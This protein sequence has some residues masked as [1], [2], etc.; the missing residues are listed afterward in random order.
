MFTLFPQEYLLIYKLHSLQN[1]NPPVSYRSTSS[2][3][4]QV[5]HSRQASNS[6]ISAFNFG[7]RS[8]EQKREVGTPT[9]AYSFLPAVNFDDFHTSLTSGEPLSNSLHGLG[10]SFASSRGVTSE[11]INKVLDN[12][13]PRRSTLAESDIRIA[14]SGSLMQRQHSISRVQVQS[15]SS[16]SKMETMGP[17]S[18]PL[19]A[20]G[21]RQSHFPTP[22]S[23]NTH[24]R[25]PRKSIG[26]GNVPNNAS[27]DYLKVRP[28]LKGE[29]DENGG[30]PLPFAERPIRAR[31][32]KNTTSVPGENQQSFLSVRNAKAKSLHAP[33]SLSHDYLSASS[34]APDNSWAMPFSTTRSPIRSND[35]GATTPSSSRRLSVMP[36]H[37]TGLGAR[38]IS[39]TDARRLKRMS[40]MP[41]PP[42]LPFTPPA[43]LPDPGYL[44]T[45]PAAESPSLIPRKS[46]TPSS[47]RTTPDPNR[48]SYCSTSSSTSYNSNRPLATT[49]RLPPSA[50]L[51]R[52]P[53]LKSR[54][55]TTTNGSEEEVPPVPAIPK[56]YESPKTELDLP[57]FAR[58]KSSL[59]DATSLNSNSTVDQLS[60]NSSDKDPQREIREHRGLALDDGVRADEQTSR[61]THNSIRNLQ[62]LRLPPLNLL[63]LNTPT[64][65]K[66]AALHDR[67]MDI[68][69]TNVTPPPRRSQLKTPS[70]PMTASKA[71]FFSRHDYKDESAPMPAHTR[72][73]SSHYA[74]RSESSSYRAASSS[75]SSVAGVTDTQT[76]L[77]PV[78]PFISSS[79]PKNSLESNSVRPKLSGDR[80]M[81]TAGLEH[82]P[83][84]LTG[85]RVQTST[86][87]VKVDPLSQPP[88]PMDTEGQSFGTSL[89]RK[90]SLN[91]KRSLSK[92][93]NA[94]ERDS[95]YPP[96]PPKHDAMPPPRLPASATWSGPWLS[97]PSPSQKPSYLHS[98]RKAS[99][100]EVA[101][102]SDRA[103]N[104]VTGDGIQDSVSAP[105]S[106]HGARLAP[107]KSNTANG[108]DYKPKLRAIDTQSDR[109]D[110][111]AE[112]EM[113]RLALRR[114]D[115]ES[116]ARELDELRRRAVPKE[117]VSPAQALRTARLNIFER[118]EIVD[119]K[120]IYFC[121][122]QTA[123]K[124]TGDLGAESANFGY[125]D[126]RGDYNIVNG[127]HLSYRYEVVDILGKGSFG[128]VVRCVDHKT[129]GLVAIKIIRNKKRFH[130]QALVEVNILQKLREWVNPIR[131]RFAL[132]PLTWIRTHRTSSVWSTSRRA[133]TSAAIFASPPNSSA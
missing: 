13:V 46:V 14:R 54:N 1:N 22:S 90:L 59:T 102:D 42:P 121:G 98:R 65:D 32:S 86:K 130:Q 3:V 51:S 38:T 128:Q 9:E 84:R 70:T 83:S 35:Q 101:I 58:R 26:P 110:L 79:L 105:S 82:K 63:P 67:A 108:A 88:S 50:S 15:S 28:S 91:R 16:A 33:A 120:E 109:D 20:K 29:A 81:S 107:P 123:K 41:N 93:E 36:G 111:I 4:R 126:E 7:T 89:R 23:T 118:G 117:K 124:F 96:Q 18:A 12:G 60:T 55:E 5:P 10:S 116:A 61:G 77:K 73:S 45:N 97:N 119:F 129:G 78:S 17:P 52:L 39:P 74:L 62:P 133:S 19:A 24:I 131:L 30:H 87:M 34:L 57:F 114:K 44:G 106:D 68:H 64:V 31:V 71:S 80:S 132:K 95:E 125:D 113:K 2:S 47:N 85:P 104:E 56:A 8:L 37:A 127:D 49:C 40:M 92:A 100:P 99:N 48:K 25:P 21:R 76:T 75:S 66:I 11:G 53:T 112:E 94:A 43:S 122:T 69:W 115:T 27:E 72:S 103:R 6:N